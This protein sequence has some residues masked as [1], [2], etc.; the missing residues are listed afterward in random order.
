MS[1]LGTGRPL[2]KYKD[3]IAGIIKTIQLPMPA[4]NGWEDGFEKERNEWKNPLTGAKIRGERR[5]RW[6]GE[7]R[8]GKI[9]QNTIDKLMEMENKTD[10]IRF[11]PRGS[12]M[13]F[14][15]GF[16]INPGPLEGNVYVDTIK[17]T[18]EENQWRDNK[19]T[20]DN[21]VKGGHV[22]NRRAII[23]R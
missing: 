20:L 12:L 9:E 3:R 11:F 6:K 1:Y 7:Y 8:F 13:S 10:L 2:I 21:I 18:V 15:C 23:R 4:R 22:P 19:P 17:I 16:E 14:V 5:Y